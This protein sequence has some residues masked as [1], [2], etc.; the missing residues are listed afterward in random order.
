MKVEGALSPGNG[1]PFDYYVSQLRGLVEAG[2]PDMSQIVNK[3]LIIIN[4]YP[5]HQITC[6]TYK[7]NIGVTSITSP[8]GMVEYY[9]YDSLGRLI[10]ITD[11]NGKI[12]K[13]YYYQ[14][15]N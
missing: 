5:N 1:Y 10:N 6:Y 15:Q 13:D 14:L 3:Q 4:Y 9:N 7:P 2:T 11:Q 12:L 8:N